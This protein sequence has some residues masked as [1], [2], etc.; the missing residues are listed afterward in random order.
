MKIQ[1][2]PVR[3]WLCCLPAILV[4]SPLLVG[5]SPPS[6]KYEIVT[7]V[8]VG[9]IPWFNRMEEGVRQA[10][11]ELDVDAYL[12]GPTQAD[13]AQQEEE[14]TLAETRAGDLEKIAEVDSDRGRQ[15]EERDG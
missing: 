7:V 15:A 5:C 6:G 11:G 2:R 14:A 3:F 4:G 10:A 1:H 13:E 12:V 8:I 9:G